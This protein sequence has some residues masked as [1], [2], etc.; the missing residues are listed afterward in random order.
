VMFEG[1][2]HT[3]KI[4]GD[5]SDAGELIPQNNWWGFSSRN[6][7]KRVLFNKL[8]RIENANT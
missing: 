3:V 4:N 1:K 5:Y 7:R 6:P 2:P 8:K